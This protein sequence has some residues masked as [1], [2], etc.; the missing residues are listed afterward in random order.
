[1]GMSDKDEDNWQYGSYRPYQHGLSEEVVSFGARLFSFKVEHW[2]AV[3]NLNESAQE[4]SVAMQGFA[5][6]WQAGIDSDIAHHPD[7]AELNVQMD[8]FYGEGQ[9]DPR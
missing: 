5:D 2:L 9:D 4:A 7:L 1:M 6:A 8:G 3:H